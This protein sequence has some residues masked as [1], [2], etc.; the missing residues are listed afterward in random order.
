MN[1]KV[2][3]ITLD[4]LNNRGYLLSTQAINNY[5]NIKDLYSN[6]LNRFLKIQK[7]DDINQG[8]YDKLMKEVK[9]RK[10][11]KFS[12]AFWYTFY[13][14]SGYFITN[15]LKFSPFFK[16]WFYLFLLVPN[17]Y[18]YYNKF[19]ENKKQMHKLLLTYHLKCIPISRISTQYDHI[20]DKLV[21]D[22]LQLYK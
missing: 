10:R 4:N 13:M 17:T 16:F 22:Y 18:F 3:I 19:Y 14:S 7:E 12:L 15:N 11:L 8:V 9:I 1:T 5:T 20:Y 2:L 21:D 6:Y